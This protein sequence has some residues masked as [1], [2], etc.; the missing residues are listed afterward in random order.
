MYWGLWKEIAEKEKKNWNPKYRMLLATCLRILR[1]VEVK[2]FRP[3]ISVAAALIQAPCIR[4]LE[5][6]IKS[7]GPFTK[8]HVKAQKDTR[9]SW[10]LS[11][12]SRAWAS[13]RPEFGLLMHRCS[14]CNPGQTSVSWAS[15]CEIKAALTIAKG[16]CKELANKGVPS[17]W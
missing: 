7:A 17:D 13:E 8:W 9:R 6:T 12:N 5:G 10:Q 11:E 1:L 3:V 16:C 4:M 14:M 2:A 15:H